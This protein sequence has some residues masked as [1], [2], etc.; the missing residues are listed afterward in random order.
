MK[1]DDDTF[2]GNDG[3]DAERDNLIADLLE[4]LEQLNWSIASKVNP[5]DN[6]RI[7]GIICGEDDF[8]NS[9]LTAID[10]SGN[11][12]DINAVHLGS[13]EDLN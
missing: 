1:Y 9:V 5:D 7:E 13:N 3:D 8:I 4:I 10:G 2:N 6:N 12:I 11:P